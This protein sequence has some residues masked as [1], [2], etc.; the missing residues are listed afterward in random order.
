[1]KKY[2]KQ[3]ITAVL[4]AAG[5]LC[6]Y[7][8]ASAKGGLSWTKNYRMLYLEQ[9]VTR[10]EAIAAMEQNEQEKEEYRQAEREK[11]DNSQ[12]SNDNRTSEDSQLSNDNQISEN[13]DSKEE[14]LLDFCIWGQKE[15][16]TLTNENLSRTAQADVILFCGNPELVFTDGE[17]IGFGEKEGCMI[18]VQTAWELFGSSNVTGKEIVCGGETYIIRKVIES[19][20]RIVAV[21][22][23]Q[24]DTADSNRMGQSDQ[25]ETQGFWDDVLN[26]ITV[27]K[28]EQLSLNETELKLSSRY[29]LGGKGLDMELLRG[30][31]GGVLLLF[32]IM[33]CMFF[34]RYLY[35][36][37]CE[38]LGEGHRTQANSWDITVKKCS[39][40]LPEAVVSLLVLGLL[41]LFLRK[42]IQIPGDY[43]PTRWSEFSFW[44]ELWQTKKE[45][46][47][48]LLQM[49][50]S[51]PDV[52]WMIS[53]CKSLGYGMAANLF[54]IFLD[55]FALSPYYSD[56]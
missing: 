5:M 55:L 44:T 13:G 8:S 14:V 24:S 12:L 38:S 27:R 37:A 21:S 15:E 52:T 1:M 51:S 7:I 56:R 53:F 42:Q 19:S 49:K 34:W 23:Y 10:K 30:I 29:N 6:I 35:Y 4:A 41:V 48:F 17:L 18:D 9:P 50:K 39:R 47:C 36:L 25:E 22:A 28:P 43:I 3:V 16:V 2:K 45:A 33:L 40:I 54:Y 20:E 32:P 11:S 31:S 46:L 26:R